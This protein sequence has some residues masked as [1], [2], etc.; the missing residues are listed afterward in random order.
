VK[1]SH[2]NYYTIPTKNDYYY[3]Y[4]INVEKSGV[5]FKREGE[6]G[7]ERERE[8]ESESEFDYIN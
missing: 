2:Y 4:F 6:R 5:C 1:N 3:Y 7:R 8:G